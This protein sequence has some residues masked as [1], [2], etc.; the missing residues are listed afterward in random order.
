MFLIR[1][2]KRN[3]STLTYKIHIL[4][5][6][7]LYPLF[8]SIILVATSCDIIHDD[9]EATNQVN[10]KMVSQNGKSTVIDLTKIIQNYEA[11]SLGSTTGLNYFDDRYL[12][13]DPKLNSTN[14]FSFHIKNTSREESNI[15]VNVAREAQTE[16]GQN[17]PFTYAKISNGEILV[18]NLLNNPEFCDYDLYQFGSI[19]LSS[20]RPGDANE[21]TTGLLMEI[22]A[23]GLQGHYAVLTYVPPVGFKGQVKFKYYLLA[24]I[25]HEFLGGGDYEYFYNPASAEFY[26]AHEVV[27]DVD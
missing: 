9:T 2:R 6:K 5:K 26:S 21:N 7:T 14:Q 19:G 4:M 23:A 13:F 25:K 1:Q 10:V 15:K 11:V 12:K 8:V 24:N 3:E 20:E 27:I 22:C 18:V 17:L 16:C